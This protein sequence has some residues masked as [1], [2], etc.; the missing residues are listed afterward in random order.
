MLVRSQ[1]TSQVDLQTELASVESFGHIGNHALRHLVA[2]W[3]QK[4]GERLMPSLRD[5][6]PA[7]I[8]SVLTQIWLCD[9]LPQGGCFR[10]RLA[11]EEINRF[12]GFSLRG[13][14]LDEIL[15]PKHLISAVKKCRMAIDLPAIV[16][17]RTH[18]SLTDA[19]TKHGERIIL[20]LSD[21]GRTVNALLGATRRDWFRDL[22]FD[23][24]TTYSQTTRVAPLRSKESLPSGRACARVDL[25]RQAD[26]RAATEAGTGLQSGFG[27]R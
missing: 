18:L 12:W 17:D 21:D 7:E 26:P 25:G 11:G 5:I 15:P 4:R 9:Y 24:F 3:F 8:P 20:P 14:Y 27:G 16:Y 23:P 22:E 1:T 10:Y 6:N 19:I 2:W 13:K